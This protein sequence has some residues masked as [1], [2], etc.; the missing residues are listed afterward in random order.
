MMADTALWKRLLTLEE[1][2]RDSDIVAID[3]LLFF[4]GFFSAHLLFLGC[5]YNHPFLSTNLLLHTAVQSAIPSKKNSID[6]F[7]DSV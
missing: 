2:L 5:A 3:A 1:V 6:L 7:S 4:V